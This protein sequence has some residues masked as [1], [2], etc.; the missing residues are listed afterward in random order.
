MDPLWKLFNKI[1]ETGQIPTEMLKSIFIAILKKSNALDCENHRTISLMSHTLKLLLKIILQRIR[2]K[3]L[4]RIPVYQYGFMPDRG[5][6]NAIFVMHMLCERSIKH[7]QNVF[8]CFIAYQKAFDKVCH[9]QLLTILKQIG[10][11]DKDFCIPWTC[12][13]WTSAL[14]AICIMS[15]KQPSNSRKDS[16]GGLKSNKVSDKNV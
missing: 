4:P 13:P 11:D 10:I 15:K 3:L 5:T 16:L 2:R 12:I 9:F 8:Q 14:Y 7:Q 6:R 1:F